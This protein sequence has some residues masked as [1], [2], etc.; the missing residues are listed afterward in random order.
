MMVLIDQ[1]KK[2]TIANKT[3]WKKVVG[4]DIKV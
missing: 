1:K 4:L 2:D 3:I